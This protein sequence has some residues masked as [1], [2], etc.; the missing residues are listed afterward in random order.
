MIKQLQFLRNAAAWVILLLSA[1]GCGGGDD[2]AKGL[3]VDGYNL[4]VITLD[5]TRADRIGAYGHTS[6]QTPNLD[7]LAGSGILFENC[8]SPVPVTLPAHASIFTGKYP[9]GHGVRNNGTYYLDEKHVT[10][11]EAF[12]ANGFQ[13]HAVI[14]AFV[15]LSKF[16][17]GQGFNVYDD[18]LSVDKMLNNFDSEIDAKKVYL[19]FKRWLD[20]NK[21]S[22]DFKFFSWLH[23]YDPHLPYDAPEPYKTKF[24][25]AP[26]QL[27][28][29]EIAFMDHYIG[30]V[31]QDL[32]EAGLLEK[33]I[34]VIVGDHG[35][36]FGEHNEYGH[37]IFCYEEAIRVPLIVY[38]SRVFEQSGLRI[39]SR[40]NIVDI[41]PTILELFGMD[42]PDNIQGRS[43]LGLLA[44]REEEKPR[45][46][47]FESM[48]GQEEMGWAPLTGLIHEKYKFISLPEPELYDLDTDSLETKNLFWKQNRLARSLD[49]RLMEMVQTYS[50]TGTSSRRKLTG[51]DKQ[52]LQSL[53]YISAFSK[54]THSNTDP[55]IGI[56]LEN[57]YNKIEELIKEKN[58]T[59]AESRLNRLAS[60][61]QKNILPQYFGMF[62]SIY[63]ER[64]DTEA[65][66]RNWRK[67]VETFPKNDNFRI[68]LG[69]ALFHAGLLQ[70]ADSVGI[71]ITKRN[72]IYT[73]AHILRGRTA[74]K[75]DRIADALIHFQQAVELEPENISLKLSYAKL[76]GQNRQKRKAW[77]TAATILAN[78]HALSDLAVKTRLGILLTELHKNEPAMRLLT[79][80]AAGYEEDEK[81]GADTWNYL[82]ILYSRQGRFG[83]AQ[84]A[85]NKSIKLDPEIARTYNNLGTLYLSLAL[86]KK[87]PAMLTRAIGVFDKALQ[88][89]ARLVSALNGRASAYKFSNRVSDALKDWKQIIVLKPG[90]ADAY[91][92]IGVTYLQLNAKSD[93]LKYLN[94]CKEKLYD[95][96]PPG[97]QQ[98]LDRLVREA[99]G[100]Q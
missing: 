75:M 6:A 2:T 55:K 19:R 9:L 94:I 49:N 90:F 88:L 64:G 30:K 41:M 71:E 70:E 65:V 45:T 16:G 21:R 82:G 11:A 56:L 27:Y 77:E 97:E 60:E 58:V 17:L 95:T 35:E 37:A 18:S 8:Y 78:E 43:F 39:E 28:D 10:M 53:G 31:I 54:E 98:R 57:R 67:A 4:L 14:A 62:N 7:Q 86:R 63:K 47:Y 99:G 20:I 15:L 85:Y 91:F 76:L 93:A 13:T 89:D 68:N 96:L 22:G 50:I 5:T 1:I 52:Q 73:M 61:G 46:F 87:E 92:N 12:T 38:N 26:E 42:E 23:F 24:G 40:V 33:T 80:A 84:D 32:S 59:E 100:Q 36:G 51:T 66:I 25:T 48:H 69:F 74:E 29:G 83:K 72:P 44:G 34:V 3:A 81:K 79:E